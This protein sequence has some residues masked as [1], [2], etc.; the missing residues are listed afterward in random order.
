MAPTT[1]PTAAR[2]IIRSQH[3]IIEY[4]EAENVI[5]MTA[6][7]PF[8]PEDEFREMLAQL[9]TFLRQQPVRKLIFD[10]RHLRHFHARSFEWLFCHWQPRMQH[11][12]LVQYCYLLP[13]DT[14]FRSEFRAFLRKIREEYPPNLFHEMQLHFCDSFLEALER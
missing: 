6:T 5:I 11:H 3:V 12:A 14:L 2:T 1:S 9:E 4:S 13:E 10:Q 8:I 7:R